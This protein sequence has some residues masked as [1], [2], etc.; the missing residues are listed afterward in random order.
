MRLSAH[1]LNS[2]SLY[3]LAEDLRDY[4][5]SLP[6]KIQQFLE[7]LADRGI[8]V[9]SVNEGDFAGYI[10]YTKEPLEGAA[11]GE[12]GI[13]LVATDRTEIT[14][15]WYV[16]ASPNA[17]MRSDTFSPLLMAEFGSGVYQVDTFDI[18]RLPDSIG[19]GGDSNGWY[20]WSDVYRDGE[21]VTWRN[22]RYLFHSYGTPPTMPMHKAVMTMI[23]EVEAIAR[24]VFG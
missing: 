14:N 9:A 22:G 3:K 12:Y 18:G 1:V 10:I 5:N 20:W 24:S 2:A 13:N 16:S 7:A 8:S 19:H 15:S 17:E 23:E 11:E 6:L 4:A 21:A